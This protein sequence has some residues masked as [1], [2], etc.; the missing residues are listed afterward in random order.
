M[1]ILS[2]GTRIEAEPPVEDSLI[3][4]PGM[5][6]IVIGNRTLEVDNPISEQLALSPDGEVV[7]ADGTVVTIDAPSDAELELLVIRGEQGPAGEGTQQFY[8]GGSEPAPTTLPLFWL[9]QTGPTEYVP[10]I[11]EALP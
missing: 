2:D 8:V 10:K 6:S 4:T 11:V 3:V 1:S 5:G 9:E 7:L